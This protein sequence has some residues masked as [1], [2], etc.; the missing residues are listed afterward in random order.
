MKETLKRYKKVGLFVFKKQGEERE[1]QDIQ[2]EKLVEIVTSNIRSLKKPYGEQYENST[3][4]HMVFSFDRKLRRPKAILA[5]GLWVFFF[6]FSNKGN[7][8]G[9]KK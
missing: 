8:K 1:I 7:I 6:F 3:I 5:A 9:F 2:M 4:R